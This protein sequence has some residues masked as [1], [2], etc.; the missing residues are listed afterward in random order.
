MRITADEA[1]VYFSDPSQ[2]VLGADPNSLPEDGCEYWADGPVCLIFHGTAHPGVW[3]VHLAAK[4]EGRGRLV[5]PARRIL[6]EFWAEHE[7]RCVVAWI[8]EHRRAAVAYA[9]RVGF[10]MHGFI[11]GTVMMDWSM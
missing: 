2:Q 4:P 10:R 9:R 1:R 7:P 3:M 8:E 6:A 11:P 5:D